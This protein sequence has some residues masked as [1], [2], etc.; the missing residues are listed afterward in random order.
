ML[1]INML[2]HIIAALRIQIAVN[3]AKTQAVNN[4]GKSGYTS[5]L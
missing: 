3:D 5:K 4:D 1:Y 2:L